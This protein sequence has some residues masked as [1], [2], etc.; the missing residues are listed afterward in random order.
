M[1]VIHSVRQ[2]T[3]VKLVLGKLEKCILLSER[4]ETNKAWG[5]G[6]SRVCH[7]FGLSIYVSVTKAMA[8]AVRGS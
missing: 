3:K 2:K 8:R 5:E 6:E 7:K 1:L 4:S